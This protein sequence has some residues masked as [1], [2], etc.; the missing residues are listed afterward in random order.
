MA[1]SFKF[2]LVSPERL[3][4]SED[5]SSV[6]VP[7]SEG[8]F[9][10]MGDHAP[11]M[12]TLK[13]GFVTATLAGGS[14]KKLFVRGGFADIN[15]NG[16]TLLAEHAASADELTSASLDESIEQ[17]R[18]RLDAADHDDARSSAELYL[19][20]LEYARTQITN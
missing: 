9:T 14:Q 11:F 3:I 4:L 16:L 13:P 17:A 18:K 12:T 20:Q 10:V 7:G 5:V 1:D 2:E 8:D 15:E 6:V 19:S